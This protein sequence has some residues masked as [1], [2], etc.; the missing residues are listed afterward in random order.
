MKGGKIR[1]AGRLNGAEYARTEFVS[2]GKM[3]LHTLR[4]NIDYGET[5]AFTTY[6]TIGVKV[7]LYK[8]QIFE[9]DTEE[10]DNTQSHT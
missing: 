7:W 8:G 1:L 4:A 3:P 5:T 10:D 2:F 6:G 9:A